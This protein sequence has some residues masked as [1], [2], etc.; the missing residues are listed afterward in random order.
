MDESLLALL[1]ALVGAVAALAGQAL[2]PVIQARRD[3]ATWLRD[4]RAES[5]EGFHQVLE[6]VREDALMQRVLR[7]SYP[8]GAPTFIPSATP[9]ELRS[10]ADSLKQAA[11]RITLYA[12][13]DLRLAASTVAV[14][15]TLLQA[16]MIDPALQSKREDAT[17]DFESAAMHADQLVRQELG[18]N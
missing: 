4:K 18:L 8:A 12:S 16:T 5:C 17:T 1:G 6:R 10:R 2:A 7:E 9:D 3:Q 14:R 11:S 13:P 15:Y